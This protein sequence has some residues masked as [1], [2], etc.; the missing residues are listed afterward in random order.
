MLFVFQKLSE[1]EVKSKIREKIMTDLLWLPR[2]SLRLRRCDV[3]LQSF[4][5]TSMSLSDFPLLYYMIGGV[6]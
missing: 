3:C 1:D 2:V 6:L 4:A 5:L